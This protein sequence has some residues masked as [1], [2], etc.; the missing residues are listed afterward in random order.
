MPDHWNPQRLDGLAGIHLQQNL[1]LPLPRLT[2]R[3]MDLA[4]SFIGGIILVPFF[5]LPVAFMVKM[6][7]RGPILY[8]QER[9][10]R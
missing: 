10:G 4:A 7:S 8:S 3:L 2:K 6:S 5:Y 1:M 9:I